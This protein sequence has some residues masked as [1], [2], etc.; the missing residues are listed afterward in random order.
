MKI[1]ITGGSGFIGTSLIDKLIKLGYEVANYD[2][3]INFINNPKYY[4]TALKFRKKI[5]KKPT[6]NF[7]GSILDKKKLR[8]IFKIFKPEVVV[9]LAGLPMARPPVEHLSHM[10]PINLD[11][12]LNVL[13][14]FE[15]SNTTKKII[16]VSSSMAYGHFTQNPQ[17]EDFVLK[18]TNLYGATKAAGEYFVKLSNKEWVILRPTSVYGFTDCANRVSQLLID[19]ALQKKSAWVVRGE[20]L[21]FSYLEDVVDGFVK[22][23]THSKAV[24]QTFNIS[25]GESRHAVEFAEIVKKYFPKFKYEV[26]KPT[27]Q[28]VYR[29]ALDISKA[30]SLLG[31]SPKY[32]IEDGIEETLNL[33]KK[34]QWHKHAYSY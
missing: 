19:A 29:G 18:P 14:E 21:D 6:F 26:K 24:F 4:K 32:S 31:F 1:L 20:S 27:N 34:H 12:S 3:L 11:G 25:R 15:E 22:A 28:Q 8:S 5:F 13:A 17:P 9:H 7:K 23:I 33:M 16:Y 10:V 30:K 2:T